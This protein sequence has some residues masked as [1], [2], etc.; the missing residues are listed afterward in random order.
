MG[1]IIVTASSF[2]L[3]ILLSYILKRIQIFRS[4]DAKFLGSLLINVNLP[5][6]I[7]SGFRD[8]E[9]D[10]SLLGAIIL[11]LGL[12]FLAIGVG[13]FVSKGKDTNSQ[14]LHM[15]GSSGYNIGI[16]TIPFV[17]SFL[18]SQA[19]IATLMFDIGNAV[20][21]FG[22]TAS[23]TT[24][25]VNHDTRNPLPA[26][27][28]K[29]FTT[30]P[31]VVYILMILCTTFGISLPSGIYVFTDMGSEATAFLAMV[32]IGLLIEFHVKL[33]DFK[34][35]SS[36]VVTRYVFATVVSMLIYFVL[37]FDIEV[38]KALIICCFSP[39]STASTVFAE[40]MGCKSTLVGVFS[41]L[42]IMISMTIIIGIVILL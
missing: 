13:F 20:M 28:K 29:L 18:N 24:A 22:T 19:L 4:E 8:F 17:A 34:A 37:P 14:I 21:V 15:M 41:S 11:A 5:C 31:F 16:F 39:L 38:R 6:V 27:L 2:V 33:D 32:M 1:Q 9:Y 10:T 3:V 40:R 42:S 25:I 35:V 30:V 36:V 26:L 7:I 23:V 12:S